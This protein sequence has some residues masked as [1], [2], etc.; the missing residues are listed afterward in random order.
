M[1][2]TDDKD[3]AVDSS[4]SILSSLLLSS[5][6]KGYI[7]NPAWYLQDNSESSTAL[8]YLML[9]HG[10]RRYTIPDV[11]RGNPKYPHIP[12]QVSQQISGHVRS[13]GRRSQPVS[14]SEILLMVENGG[15]RVMT[16][17]EQGKFLFQDFEYPDNTPYWIQILGNMRN[18]L[19]ELVLDKESFPKLIH[20]TQS[21]TEAIP[22]IGEE[23]QPD[24]F[25]SKAE[26]RSMYD[27]DMRMIHLRG[28]SNGAKN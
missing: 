22:A 12:Y 3:I 5:E 15:V 6:L 11:I 7:E 19:D 8:D 18:N 23:T 17:D 1:A 2:I 25:I 27:D 13:T 26:Q 16:T 21:S 9:T 10:W 28:R 14:N 4:N 20:A 24:D